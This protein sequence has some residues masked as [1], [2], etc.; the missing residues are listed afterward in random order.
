MS[1]LHPININ[2]CEL[3][4]RPPHPSPTPHAHTHTHRHPHT[5]DGD[6]CAH[7]LN[8]YMKLHRTRQILWPLK[9][10]TGASPTTTT[11]IIWGEWPPPPIQSTHHHTKKGLLY[12]RNI[13]VKFPSDWNKSSFMHRLMCGQAPVIPDPHNHQG[14]FLKILQK[15]KYWNSVTLVANVEQ[16]SK[17]PTVSNFKALTYKNDF[18]NVRY[19]KVALG[20]I[21]CIFNEV[22]YPS[23]W[24]CQ[25]YLPREYS[26]EVSK[27]FEKYFSSYRADDQGHTEGQTGRCW[28]YSFGLVSEG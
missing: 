10:L 22:W 2:V 27:S 1:A 20:A 4:S 11:T 8:S 28:Q 24:T 16:S 23:S 26:S 7:P 14:K 3:E 17:S 13:L 5:A 19:V 21:M 12:L 6:E 25:R 18:R 15:Y 9:Q